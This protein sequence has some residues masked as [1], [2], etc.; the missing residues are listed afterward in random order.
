MTL[1]QFQRLRLMLVLLG[2]AAKLRNANMSRRHPFKGYACVCPWCGKLAK[3]V[4]FQ[5][6]CPNAKP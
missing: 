6:D 1:L 5:L 4:L 3:Q 2:R